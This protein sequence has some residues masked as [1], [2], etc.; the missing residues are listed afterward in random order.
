MELAQTN[1]TDT[2]ARFK[3]RTDPSQAAAALAERVLRIGP[4]DRQLQA[5][6][7]ALSSAATAMRGSLTDQA[8]TH[9]QRAASALNAQLI[10]ALPGA[11]NAES[12][13]DAMQSR[14][15]VV[16]WLNR[17]APRSRP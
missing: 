6:S 4:A 14:G 1:G 8:R 5:I 2:I 3:R 7:S 16:E 11:P 9:L 13:L 10:L 12:S 17:A 15:A